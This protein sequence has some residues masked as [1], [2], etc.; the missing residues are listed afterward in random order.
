MAQTTVLT[1]D[2]ALDGT[3]QNVRG[4]ID[5]RVP[6]SRVIS[7]LLFAGSKLLVDEEVASVTVSTD[8]YVMRISASGANF[9]VV[10]TKVN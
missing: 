1:F 6:D 9:S 8:Q 3:M 10:V 4:S 5:G 7:R 2:I